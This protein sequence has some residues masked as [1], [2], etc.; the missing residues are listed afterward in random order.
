MPGLFE[1]ARAMTSTVPPSTSSYE[2]T[3]T[4]T[5]EEVKTSTTIRIGTPAIVSSQP[6]SGPED[7]T[8]DWTP[9]QVQLSGL[10]LLLVFMMFVGLAFA[11][12][13]LRR[14]DRLRLPTTLGSEQPRPN[15]L[16]LI[17][18]EPVPDP[19]VEQANRAVDRMNPFHDDMDDN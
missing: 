12:I 4:T 19:I 13:I 5:W 17:D 10:Y 2:T 11:V 9:V 15:R 16:E 8:L 18:L 7:G 14:L 1:R 6:A 3:T